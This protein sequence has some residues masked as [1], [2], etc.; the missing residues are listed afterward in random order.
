M[1]FILGYIF[2]QHLNQKYRTL[3]WLNF[4]VFFRQIAVKLATF[5]LPLFLYQ[6]P[7]DFPAGHWLLS[8]HT[9]I[10]QGMILLA[11]FYLVERL[12]MIVTAMPF[13]KLTRKI[14][15]DRMLIIGLAI[16]MLNL[17]A[18]L[19]LKKD[20]RLF[21]LVAILSGL[22]VTSYWHSYRTLLE[23]NSYKKDIG[24]NTCVKRLLDNIVG[25]ISPIVG[26]VVIATFGYDY[27]F[28]AALGAILIA[29]IGTLN[30]TIKEELDEVN[31]QEYWSWVKERSFRKLM[32]SQS[33]MI[34]NSMVLM[35]WP[36]YV[37]LLIGDVE[38]VGIIYSLS[39][40]LAIV[41]NYF[42]GANLDKKRKN[43][44]PYF[45]SGLLLSILT[46]LKVGVIQVWNVVVIDSLD[47]LVGNF[48][49]LIYD[50]AIMRRA[51]GSQDFS[52]FVYRQINHSWAALVFWIL[53]LIFFFLCPVG[54]TGV[55]LLGSV[56]V[57]MS[58]LVNESKE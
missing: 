46:F 41:I 6:L 57:L 25:V 20:I 43:K 31:W 9:G 27:L 51:K 30:L 33:G 10:Q 24:K 40:F 16:F 5:Y 28:Y 39:L 17:I 2:H 58:L 56:G 11:S 1:H 23:R 50:D 44:L 47:R 32:I 26:G 49:W 36:L 22:K 55:F 34:F 4:S 12:A 3:R 35:L 52:Y 13:A 45:I 38:K 18:L 53:F 54:W 19:Y 15:H 7:D 42:V 21:P 48:H 37:F 8:G 29:M 14:G